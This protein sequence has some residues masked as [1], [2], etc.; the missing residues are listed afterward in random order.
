LDEPSLTTLSLLLLILFGLSAFFSGSETALIALNRY[1]LRHLAQQGHPGAI[2]AQRLLAHPDR[3]ITLILLGNNFVNIL[4]TQLATYLG[5]R[6]FGNTGVAFATGLL[7][8]ALLLFAEVTPKTFAAVHSERL[9]YPAAFVFSP[10]LKLAAP[11]V[12]LVNGCARL[13]LRALRV[14]Q[15]HPGAMD[16]S[17]DELRTLM[18]ESTGPLPESHREMLLGLLDLDRRTVEDIMVPRNEIVGI[19]LEDD[20]DE[21]VEELRNSMYT[22]LP[23]WRG[24]PDHILGF[25]HL[26]KLIPLLVEDDLTRPALE[27]AI[28]PPLFI[29]E[30]TTLLQ[31]LANFRREKRRVALVVDEYGDIL[32]LVT[33]EDLLE[34]IVGEFTTD[35]ATYSR[36]VVP[37]EDGSYI[38]DGGVHVRELNRRLGWDLPEDGPRTLNGLILEHMEFIPGPGTSLMINGYPMEIIQATSSAVKTVRIRP[39]IVRPEREEAD[40]D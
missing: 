26:R 35:P 5:Y 13:L 20:W 36:D 6:L 8:L 19:D 16:L 4:I 15:E 34:E 1:R 28:R 29:P 33:L 40:A 24:S 17:R 23:V 25:V 30:G 38:V 37:Q 21:I 14:P 27:K 39:R 12:W 10:L 22:R 7:T 2:R 32:G 9:A 3:L 31:A 18:S 11:L